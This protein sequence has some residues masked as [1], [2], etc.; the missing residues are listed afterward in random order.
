MRTARSLN[1]IRCAIYTRKST[2]EGL[3]QEFN[4][5]DAQRESGE[6]YIKSQAQEG[7]TLVKDRYDDGGFTGGN[8]E[9]PALARLM[10]D[11]RAG[12]IDCVVVY[13]VD[14]L[15]RSLLDFAK[16][17]E[18]FERH[19]VAF[20]SVTQE[21]NTSTSMGR[22][23][24]NVLLSFAQFEREVISERTRDKIAAARRKGKWSGGLPLLGYDVDPRT[25]KLV[26]N[27]AEAQ[28]VRAIFELYL[29]KQ[30][31][32]STAEELARRGWANKR[33]TTRQGRLR[34]GQPFGKGRL[35]KL[36]TN[37]VYLGKIRYKSEIHEGEQEAIISS[38]VWERVQTLLKQNSRGE[39]TRLGLRSGAL[40]KGLLRCGPCGCAL[41]PAHSTK[42]HTC[43]RYYVCV[44]AQQ[45]GWKSCPT[46]SVSAEPV[47]RF[48]VAQLRA[49]SAD[50]DVAARL[51]RQD[52]K[53]LAE[54]GREYQEAQEELRRCEREVS[55]LSRQVEAG[56]FQDSKKLATVERQLEVAQREAARAREGLTVSEAAQ[57][58]RQ[59]ALDCWQLFDP[60]WEGLEMAS[61]AS[62]LGRLIEYVEY[63]RLANALAIRLKPGPLAT[64]ATEAAERGRVQIAQERTIRYPFRFQSGSFWRKKLR[65][66]TKEVAA[67]AG[68][69]PRITRLM[70]LAIRFDQLRRSGDVAD[71][72][73]LA[74]LGQVSR[75]RITQ[76]MN[77]LHLAPDIQEEIL[78]LPCVQRGRDPIHLRQ[79]Q[80][81]TALMSWRRQRSRWRALRS[82]RARRQSVT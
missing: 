9:R 62:I 16:M 17:M 23:M 37:V 24:L 69:L 41:S 80:P 30:S 45:R 48:V 10:A 27:Q 67:R 3:Q 47:E 49:L 63:D 66:R 82:R 56:R 12:Q 4:S 6:A 51:R 58:A 22:L 77:L 60:N 36:L 46:K 75:A 40:L 13:K 55:R 18:T 65:L 35:H 44:Q 34:G 73:T 8:M 29:E 79:L 81:I 78:F 1:T 7:W 21:F 68:R 14:R 57:L 59:E 5:L 64:V 61:Q 42:N 28:R 20:V 70:A 31:L 76:V 72:V 39:G 26:V 2:E 53:R 74:K 32:L 19:R 11:M 33:W 50:S 15:S 54:V 52:Q 25:H 43:Y 71:Y 38:E